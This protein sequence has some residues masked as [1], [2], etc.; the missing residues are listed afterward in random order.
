M[1]IKPRF[2]DVYYFHIIYIIC[3]VDVPFFYEF[4]KRRTV[5]ETSFE[6]FLNG[7]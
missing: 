7:F 6:G 3:V 4:I 1:Y 5:N 2:H